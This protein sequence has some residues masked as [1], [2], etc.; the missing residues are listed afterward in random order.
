MNRLQQ[1]LLYNAV[2]SGISGLTLILFQH[3]I[4]QL[5]GTANTKVYWVV[6]ALL[7]FFTFTIVFEMVKQRPLGVL[8]II[9]QDILWVLGSVI[10]LAIN[11]FSITF[12][13]NMIIAHVAIIV[14]FMAINQ[15]KALGRV[16]EKDNSG[17]KV[18]RSERSVRAPK[19]DVWHL[20]SDVENYHDVAP[21][22]DKSEII[23]GQGEGMVRKCSHRNDSWTETCTTWIE[24]ASY[25]F[26]VNTDAPDYPYPLEFL[27][28][29]W[30]V[31]KLAD[32][33]TNIVMTFELRYKRKIYNVILHP[34]MKSKFK[35]IIE[36]LLDNWQNQLE[37]GN[38]S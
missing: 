18:L 10:L 32:K 14:L 28:G 5:F 25:T 4:A 2:F 7:I 20:I 29:T 35:K 22:I 6:G 24:E 16:D 23:S 9:V 36:E 38:E 3:S 26:K 8:W 37:G 30:E 12:T 31:Q 19:S 13:G 21:N 17:L 33:Q 11:P 1:S 27:R 34:V 15:A